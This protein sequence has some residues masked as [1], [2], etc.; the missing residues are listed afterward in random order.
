[1]VKLVGMEG[2][3]YPGQDVQ[4]SDQT[5]HRSPFCRVCAHGVPAPERN[6]VDNW[7]VLYRQW[8]RHRRMHVSSWVYVAGDHGTP[9]A[10][11]PQG[12]ADAVQLL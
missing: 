7:A 10:S 9:A 11:K 5:I 8:S 6:T 3:S 4:M 12:L 1:M 2:I